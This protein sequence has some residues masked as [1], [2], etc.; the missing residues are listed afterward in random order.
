MAK[1]QHHKATFDDP[2]HYLNRE[3]GE[4]WRRI[5][6][7]I[8]WPQAG[9]EGVGIVIGETVIEPYA[10]KILASVTD[11]N[12]MTLLEKCKALEGGY[13]V[14]GWHGNAFNQAMMFLHYEFNKGRAFEDKLTFAGAPLAGEKNNSGY[15]LPKVI[16]LGVQHRIDALAAPTVLRELE[17]D[18]SWPETHLNRDIADFPPLAALCYPLSYLQMYSGKTYKAIKPNYTQKYGDKAYQL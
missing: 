7:G 8:G 14:K 2:A 6:G 10:Y 11:H 18:D 4:K 15:Y 1:F 17:S 13:P 5:V 3:T 16:E 9:Q 12:A